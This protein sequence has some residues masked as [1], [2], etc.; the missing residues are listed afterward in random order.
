MEERAWQRKQENLWSDRYVHYLDS[1]DSFT[2]HVKT[3]V[4]ALV[5]SMSITLQTLTPIVIK[6]IYKKQGRESQRLEQL[7]LYTIT[8][9]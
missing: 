2:A 4:N 1:G 7:A 5:Y 8:K 9:D 6:F 3:T